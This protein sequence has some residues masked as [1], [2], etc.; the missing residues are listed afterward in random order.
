MVVNGVGRSVDG[1]MSMK[2]GVV[3]MIV[4]KVMNVVVG[5][6]IEEWVVGDR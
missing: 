1:E 2:G 5:N 3:G 4:E 6:G